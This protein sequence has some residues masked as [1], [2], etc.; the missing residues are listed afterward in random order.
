MKIVETFQTSICIHCG[1]PRIVSRSWIEQVE[2]LGGISVITHT[3]TVCA[4][5][6]CQK[7]VDK[8]LKDQKA[9]RDALKRESELREQKRQMSLKNS[10]AHKAANL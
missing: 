7:I 10:R 9:K 5:L 8:E 1:K 6:D 2:T 3:E 4:D